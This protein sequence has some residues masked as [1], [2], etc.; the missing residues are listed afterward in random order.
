MI[1]DGGSGLN[2]VVQE[3]IKKLNLKIKR[4]PNPL[5]VA[6]DSDSFIPISCCCLITFLFG[7]DFEESI[8]CKVLTIKISH[9]YLEDFGFLIEEVSMTITKINILSYTMGVRRSFVRKVPPI[10]KPKDAQPKTVLT[11]CQFEK[12]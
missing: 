10:K 4:H 5:Q 8:W 2:M 3:L 7:K 9:I 12:V 11:M 6:W 1:I